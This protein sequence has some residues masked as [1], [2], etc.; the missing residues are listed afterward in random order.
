MSGLNVTYG[1]TAHMRAAAC[2]PAE[3]V[4]G[5]AMLAAALLPHLAAALLPPLLPFQPR[6]VALLLSFSP[7]RAWA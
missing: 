3:D 6:A 7:S 4:L 2:W 5:L 1:R